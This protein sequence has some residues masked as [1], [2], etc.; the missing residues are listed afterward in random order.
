MKRIQLATVLVAGAMMVITGCGGGQAGGSAATPAPAQSG[1]GAGGKAEG[2]VKTDAP[3]GGQAATPQPAGA[4]A[5]PPAQGSSVTQAATAKVDTSVSV[6]EALTPPLGQDSKD[7]AL[8]PILRVSV[9]TDLR[10]ARA[11]SG[12]KELWS[13]APKENADNLLQVNLGAK[14]R[15]AEGK[16][17][18]FVE[19]QAGFLKPGDEFLQ[20]F[21][22]EK[23]FDQATFS[24]AF[25]IIYLVEKDG[26]AWKLIN[27]NA[28]KL[29]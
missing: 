28:R 2:P 20:K 29:W 17:R 24:A 8:N 9:N 6:P 12:S 7:V 3:A 16:D 18:Y 10:K 21:N 27:S 23:K 14:M 1:G 13:A 26:N 11:T 19:A 22:T 4:P 15:P 5:S 25:N